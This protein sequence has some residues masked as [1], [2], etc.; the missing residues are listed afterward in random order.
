M[1]NKTKLIDYIDKELEDIKRYIRERAKCY[2]NVDD[3]VLFDLDMDKY[4][5]SDYDVEDR[6]NHNFDLGALYQLNKI[7]KLIKDEK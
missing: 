6:E 3:E 4:P 1:K 7:L 2:E 5:V